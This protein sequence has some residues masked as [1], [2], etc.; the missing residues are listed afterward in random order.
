MCKT[1]ITTTRPRPI[2][3]KQLSTLQGL[4][5]PMD[6]YDETTNPVDFKRVRFSSTMLEHKYEI[7][8][9]PIFTITIRDEGNHDHHSLLTV[10]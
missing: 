3:V 10:G 2:R 8:T 1:T 7:S 4:L 5:L 6:R 9:H